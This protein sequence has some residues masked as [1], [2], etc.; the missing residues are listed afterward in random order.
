MEGM[1][2]EIV[3]RPIGIIRSPFTDP[4][5]MPIQPVSESSAPGVAEV[6]EE[7]AEALKDLDGFSHVILL[8]HFHRVNR[9]D[10]TV[11]PF[12]GTE[13]RGLFATRAPTRPNPIGLSVVELLSINGRRLLLKNVDILDGTPLLDIKP[14]VPQ[15]DQPAAARAGWLEKTDKSVRSMKS[16]DRFV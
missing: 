7:Y 4:R 1:L 16:D 15:F 5:N 12:M 11:T 6:F 9:V 8:Y 3:Y 14:Y 2:L 10:L 13:A